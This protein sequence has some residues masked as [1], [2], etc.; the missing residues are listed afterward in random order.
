M[1]RISHF[2]VKDLVFLA[3]ILIYVAIDKDMLP[4]IYTLK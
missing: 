2:L 4:V 3:Y 1:A